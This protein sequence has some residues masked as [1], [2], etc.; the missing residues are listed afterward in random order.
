VCEMFG[1]ILVCEG[2]C[3]R[4]FH[5]ACLSEHAK[6][7]YANAL[8][9][10][11]EDAAFVCDRYVCAVCMCMCEWVVSVSFVC[12]YPTH[13]RAHIHAQLRERPAGVRAVP[14]ARERGRAHVQM[15]QEVWLLLPRGLPQGI[16]GVCVR[17]C[18]CV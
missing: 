14:R 11:S 16:P 7:R 13:T 3:K 4:G 8:T 6:E 1:D 17:V 18:E 12:D 15:Q 2:V 9:Q 5:Q 10:D